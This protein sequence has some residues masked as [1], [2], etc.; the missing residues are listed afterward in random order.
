MTREEIDEMLKGFE[1]PI[2]ISALPDIMIR[3]M[4]AEAR[5]EFI[6]DNITQIAAG[7]LHKD[8]EECQDKMHRFYD[9]IMREKITEL[10]G[11]YGKLKD[12]TGNHAPL[13]P[14]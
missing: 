4:V 8:E 5:L 14:E 6:W 3:L 10:I 2:P 7:A 11:K 1:I 12:D 9:E 13:P